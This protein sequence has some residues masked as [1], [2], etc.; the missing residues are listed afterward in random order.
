MAAVP[1]LAVE[2]A[3]RPL[4]QS[5]AIREDLEEIAPS[6]RCCRRTRSGG[7]GCGRSRSVWLRHASVH[8]A[9]GAL[10]HDRDLWVRCG[11]VAGLADA[12]AADGIGGAR[13]AAGDR[14]GHGSVL[15]WRDRHARE[16]LPLFG[17][18]RGAGVRDPG[19]GRAEGRSHRGALRGDGA[20]R[21][22]R[23]VPAGRR[24]PRPQRRTRSRRAAPGGPR[25]E[26]PSA[27]PVSRSPTPARRRSRRRS[28][29]PSR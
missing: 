21:E 18:G 11:A 19:R 10:V 26:T 24:T 16:Y 9:A 20:V 17:G 4:T 1:S 28:R 5:L 3:D 12:L 6:R 22:R 8:H 25:G 23:P 7:R 2:G 27:A 14:R 15:P 13:P 29:V